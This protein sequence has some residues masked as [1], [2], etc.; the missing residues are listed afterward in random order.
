L[1]F[2]RLLI[3]VEGSDDARFFENIIKPVIVGYDNILIRPYAQLS[4]K[5]RNGLIKGAKENKFDYLYVTDINDSK[6]ATQKKEDLLSYLTAGEGD[7]IRIVKKEIESWYLA[8]LSSEGS[9][10]FGIWPPANTEYIDKRQFGNLTPKRFESKTD[11]MIE[12]LKFFSTEAGVSKNKS[13]E[14]LVNKF[15]GSR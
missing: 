4:K 12:I 9:Q 6:C 8:G 3:F 2:K 7:K 13:F 14:Y 1:F 15:K 11:F 10:N 5:A